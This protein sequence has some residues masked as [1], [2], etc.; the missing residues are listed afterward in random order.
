M[1]RSAPD[2]N[3]R[4]D[5]VALDGLPHKKLKALA[6]RTGGV[7]PA[8]QSSALLQAALRHFSQSPSGAAWD[9]EAS[10]RDQ[11]SLEVEA[12]EGCR[13]VTRRGGCS[14]AWRAGGE[15]RDFLSLEDPV[16]LTLQ[17]LPRPQFCVLAREKS[18]K[19]TLSHKMRVESC[20]AGS[21]GSKEEEENKEEN[22]SA[23]DEGE[24]EI[25]TVQAKNRGGYSTMS[26]AFAGT[27][28][29]ITAHSPGECFVTL[30]VKNCSSETFS[31]WHVKVV[32]R[33]Q[34]KP[35]KSANHLLE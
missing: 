1:K 15:R 33:P 20:A 23:A 16:P 25:V 30:T 29:V 32:G 4:L 7:V 35:T 6:K 12:D 27:E 19:M 34:K 26:K 18:G 28:Y 14:E 10:K 22:E 21:S 24:E 17:L 3:R 9:A 2:T 13:V 31:L 5:G 8:N 11:A